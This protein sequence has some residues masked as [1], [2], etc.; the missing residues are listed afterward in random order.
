MMKKL[1][2]RLLVAVLIAMSSA[3]AFRSAR[4]AD[5]QRGSYRYEDR[6]VTINGIVTDSWGVPLVPYKYYR[7][8]DGTG[9]IM[10]LSQN[11]RSVPGN[12]ARVRVK[13]RVNSVAVVGGKRIGLHLREQDLDIK[14]D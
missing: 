8:D 9:E 2:S 11:V 10:V 12:G 5:L 14:R 6:S 3:C 7:V 1:S 4:I 13:G